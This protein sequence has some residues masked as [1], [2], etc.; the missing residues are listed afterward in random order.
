M[1]LSFPVTKTLPEVVFV[2]SCIHDH[3]H[4]NINAENLFGKDKKK[5]LGSIGCPY[6]ETSLKWRS[7]TTIYLNLLKRTNA[8]ADADE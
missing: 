3:E 7:T 1:L 2:I 6:I 5:Q 8:L 4:I